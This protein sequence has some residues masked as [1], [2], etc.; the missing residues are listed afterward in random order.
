MVE[1]RPR[2][3]SCPSSTP[4]SERPLAGPLPPLHSAVSAPLAAPLPLQQALSLAVPI[5]AVVLQ[6]YFWTKVPGI[7]C[8]PVVR[9]PMAELLL[10]GPPSRA[11]STSPGGLEE[12][13]LLPAP[14][15]PGHFPRNQWSAVAASR[16]Q[17]CDTPLPIHYST[18]A[19]LSP[20]EFPS[21]AVPLALGPATAAAAAGPP[22][23]DGWARHTGS[24]TGMENGGFRQVSSHDP[25]QCPF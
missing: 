15:A 14:R 21:L 13:L 24:G 9:V 11:L 2:G 8:T 17:Y 22:G 1:E 19:P 3:C 20:R 4:C 12:A 25:R 5:L 7:A 16:P 6:E 10:Q 18:A 23:P